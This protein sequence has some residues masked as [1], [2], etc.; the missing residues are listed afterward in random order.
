MPDL[1]LQNL[2]GG[3]VTL[4]QGMTATHQLPSGYNGVLPLDGNYTAQVLA[5]V[6]VA[7]QIT[8]SNSG[9]YI[10][11][12]QLLLTVNNG[13]AEN[14]TGVSFAGVPHG[15]LPNGATS[16]VIE[17]GGAIQFQVNSTSYS[18]AALGADTA[19]LQIY[20]AGMG[21]TWTVAD[22]GT[23][24]YTTNYTTNFGGY[25]QLGSFT[26]AV[27]TKGVVFRPTS[28][29]VS[30]F[31]SEVESFGMGFV[32]GLT[33]IMFKLALRTIRAIP[34]GGDY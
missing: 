19:T 13:A 5:P 17:H 27:T 31:E 30:T 26:P 28:L 9:P 4:L 1:N 7:M 25:T 6:T 22:Y 14:C 34:T 10:S 33:V 16:V 3:T 29:D 8:S 32:F 20:T 18:I 2:S 15:D 21:P 24:N 12:F 11:N 23:T